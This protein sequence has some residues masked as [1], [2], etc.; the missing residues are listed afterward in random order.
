MGQVSG[1]FPVLGSP[2]GSEGIVPIV[3]L[4]SIYCR[5][6]EVIASSSFKYPS[7]IYWKDKGVPV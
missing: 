3:Q 7:E 4:V 6:S 2:A 1:S 5:H